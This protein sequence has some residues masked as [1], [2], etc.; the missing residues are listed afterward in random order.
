MKATKSKRINRL[1]FLC[2]QLVMLAILFVTCMFILIV[3]AFF[4]PIDGRFPNSG[5]YLILAT[6]VGCTIIS[7]RN[8]TWRLRDLGYSPWFALFYFVPVGSLVLAIF[9]YFIPGTDSKNKYGSK[10][11]GIELYKVYSFTKS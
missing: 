2:A 5:V 1:T 3:S 7:V 4:T 6:A 8:F 10:P 11:K 9:A